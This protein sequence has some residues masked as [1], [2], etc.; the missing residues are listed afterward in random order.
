MIEYPSFVRAALLTGNGGGG[1]R[2]ALWGPAAARSDRAPRGSAGGGRP[3][4]RPSRGTGPRGRAADVEHVHSDATAG[5]TTDGS[6]TVAPRGPHRPGLSFGPGINLEAAA[7]TGAISC[8]SVPALPAC[9]PS[10]WT[11]RPGPPER[12]SATVVR[13]SNRQIVLFLACP[14]ARPPS[15]RC[16]QDAVLAWTCPPPPFLSSSSSLPAG[17]P[18]VVAEVLPLG[19]QQ[20]SD[21]C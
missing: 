20:H 15:G 9:R 4:G 17:P 10:V 18:D 2:A 8:C 6:E 1:R 7:L 12:I 13:P 3:S 21:N 11:A 19:R 5:R 14:R 16:R